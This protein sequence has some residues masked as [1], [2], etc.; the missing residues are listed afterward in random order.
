[1]DVGHGS[2][3][4]YLYGWRRHEQYRS[5]VRDDLQLVLIDSFKF[6]SIGW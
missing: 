6:E 5:H 1:M 4:L 3:Y 2:K